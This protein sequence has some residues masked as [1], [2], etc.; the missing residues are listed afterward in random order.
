MPLLLAMAWSNISLE[1]CNYEHDGVSVSV[2]ETA[3]TTK[4]A[5]ASSPSNDSRTQTANG[6]LT[7][8]TA[9]RVESP[10]R[11]LWWWRNPILRSGLACLRKQ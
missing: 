3:A 7:P 1:T 10:S 2:R 9:E 11:V 5:S 6:C 4:P 8:N